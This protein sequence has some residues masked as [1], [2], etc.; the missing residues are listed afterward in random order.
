MC[1]C[2]RAR[3][4]RRRR[5]IS[6]FLCTV[7]MGGHGARSRR[8]TWRST[9]LTRLSGWQA[10]M[11][12]VAAAVCTNDEAA[13]HGIKGPGFQRGTRDRRGPA[14]RSGLD[15]RTD[16]QL[17]RRRRR[18]ADDDER[19]CGCLPGWPTDRPTNPDGGCGAAAANAKR[20][21]RT[22]PRGLGPVQTDKA[23]A[24]AGQA[25]IGGRPP[26]AGGGPRAKQNNKHKRCERNKGLLCSGT[27]AAEPRLPKVR[28]CLL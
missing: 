22:R 21:S 16:G 28:P 20:R 5:S 11:L 9:P 24:G 27:G 19:A 26:A 17:R 3:P 15:G 18:R 6:P 2:A 8:R 4:A 7:H 14:G 12:T 13:Q 10:E 23:A 1:V 25:A